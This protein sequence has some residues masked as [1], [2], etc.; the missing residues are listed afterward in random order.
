M[1]HSNIFHSFETLRFSPNDLYQMQQISNKGKE[2][3][4]EDH[5]DGNKDPLNKLLMLKIGSIC[6]KKRKRSWLY[7][8][9]HCTQI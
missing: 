3:S 4:K 2:E 9:S 5:H 8:F 1:I 7:S 6:T